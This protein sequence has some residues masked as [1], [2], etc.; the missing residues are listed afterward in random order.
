MVT[1][2]NLVISNQF[3]HCYKSND[4]AKYEFAE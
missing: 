4:P 1:S 2:M 3:L